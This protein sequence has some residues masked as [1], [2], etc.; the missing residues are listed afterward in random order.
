[1]QERM[2]TRLL[3]SG[4]LILLCLSSPNLEWRFT[5]WQQILGE[6]LEFTLNLILIWTLTAKFS[7]K[8]FYIG[9]HG[10]GCSPSVLL[11]CQMRYLIRYN[12]RT[13]FSLRHK[14]RILN[15]SH[16]E[17]GMNLLALFLQ[18]NTLDHPEDPITIEVWGMDEYSCGV[19]R[20]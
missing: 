10:V 3:G 12:C 13:I 5:A 17:F 7:A 6:R 19:K 1:M 15:Y 8:E 16:L 20:L 14:R 9:L 18:Y 11:I 2:I 4:H